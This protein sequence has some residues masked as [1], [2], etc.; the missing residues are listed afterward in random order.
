MPKHLYM[1]KT[2]IFLVFFSVVLM[3]NI[4]LSFAN[5]HQDSI[6]IIQTDENNNFN[7]FSNYQFRASDRSDIN[8]TNIIKLNFSSLL[9]SNI[10]VQY[11][12]IL[13]NKV[14]LALGVRFMPKG[15]LPLSNTVMSFVEYDQSSQ[16]SEEGLADFFD[17]T[18]VGGFA[19]TPEF[20]Y[21]FK[22]AG[23]GLYLAPYFR[24][25]QYNLTST[26]T[27]IDHNNNIPIDFIGKY[28]N[29][30]GG[31]MLGCQFNLG[32]RVTLDW[33]IF[34][35]FVGTMNFNLNASGYTL[36]DDEYKAVKEDFDD[37]NVEF[38]NYKFEKKLTHSSADVSIKGLS[39]AI[40]SFGINLGIKF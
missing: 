13:G 5:N 3:T 6:V 24:Y 34:G 15:R 27:F 32:E 12:K 23:R 28:T 7:D 17:N 25:G 22:Q 26:Y 18:K 1:N 29:I 40:R 4:K 9:L 36:T 37:F 16:E 11:E 21:Y 31:I 39:T 38:L 14:S 35:P 8:H 2:S 33:W 30:G 10:A 19:I 20:R